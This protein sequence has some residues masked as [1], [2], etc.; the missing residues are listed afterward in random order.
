MTLLPLVQLPDG[1]APLAA[2]V[3]GREAEM[4]E[5]VLGVLVL[6][7]SGRRGTLAKSLGQSLV[8]VRGSELVLACWCARG[9]RVLSGW[10]A[11]E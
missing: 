1:A 9:E 6:A 3:L 8:R 11:E 5:A 4:A 10:G 7:K 2:G